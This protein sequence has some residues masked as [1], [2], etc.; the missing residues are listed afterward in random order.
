MS[1]ET[2]TDCSYCR[3]K[4]FYSDE[5]SGNETYCLCREGKTL[6]EMEKKREED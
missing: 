5:L 1:K 6:M 3:G 4:G 2:P